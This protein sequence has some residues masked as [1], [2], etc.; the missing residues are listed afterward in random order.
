LNRAPALPLADAGFDLAVCTVSVEYLVD[1]VA[2]FREVGRVLRPGAV[3][4]VVCSERWFPPK[5]IRVWRE[6]H[7]FERMGLVLAWLR[8][9]GGFE[10]LHTESVRGLPRPP[11]D[12]YA[13]RLAFADPVHAV[14]GRAAGVHATPGRN[15]R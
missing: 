15:A 3:F 14:W 9:A 8:Q 10:G 11:D 2:V 12:R 5:V 13:G 7:P 4:A 6:L 1:P